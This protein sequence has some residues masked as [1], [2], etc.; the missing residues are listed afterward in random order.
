MAKYE[1]VSV[2]KE[3][4]ELLSSEEQF[5]RFLDSTIWKDL[6]AIVE[7]WEEGI[8]EAL[9]DPEIT[10]SMEWVAHFQGRVQM[11]K[12]FLS[13]PEDTIDALEI[14]RLNKGEQNGESN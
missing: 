9:A 2:D 7:G 8:K 14:D 13:L 6:K 10:E 5:K 12:L 11:C 1:L 4:Y 3:E